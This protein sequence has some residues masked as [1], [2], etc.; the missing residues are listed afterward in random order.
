MI[1]WMLDKRLI[2]LFSAIYKVKKKKKKNRIINNSTK[3]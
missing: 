2:Q 3:F 1:K